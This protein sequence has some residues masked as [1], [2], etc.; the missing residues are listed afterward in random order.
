MVLP[1]SVS[2]TDQAQPPPQQAAPPD[3][4]LYVANYCRTS[5]VYPVGTH[6]VLAEMTHPQ[7]AFGT[8]IDTVPA[9]PGQRHDLRRCG[10]LLIEEP[11]CP[12]QREEG[13]PPDAPSAFGRRVDP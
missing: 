13:A 2:P 6:L 4:P 1:P 5:P 3:V 8:V 9:I 11:R 12:S 7:D 10:L